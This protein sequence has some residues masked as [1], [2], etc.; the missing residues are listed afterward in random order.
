LGRR[1]LRN[2]T[3]QKTNNSIENLVENEGNKYSLT[4]IS[5]IMISVSNELHEV[6]KEML[7]KEFQKLFIGEI[8]EELQEKLKENTQKQLKVYQ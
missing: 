4:D 2:T 7:K 1:R 3:S 6:N 5:R 8:R